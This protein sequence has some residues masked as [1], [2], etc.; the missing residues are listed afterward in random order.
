MK[1]SCI[2][3][4]R[5]IKAAVVDVKSSVLVCDDLDV[6]SSFSVLDREIKFCGIICE[7][8]IHLLEKVVRIREKW[9]FRFLP[10]FGSARACQQPI[11]YLASLR[12]RS[13]YG[14]LILRERLSMVRTLGTLSL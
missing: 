3:T 9:K 1:S 2:L 13:V 6:L 14:M 10:K 11:I 4:A 8:M 5:Y 12:F 7:A